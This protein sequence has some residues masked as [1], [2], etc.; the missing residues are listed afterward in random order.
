[1]RTEE[2]KDCCKF[3]EIEYQKLLSSCLTR[4]LSLY[5]SLP[6]ILQMYPNLQL[7]FMC[8]DKPPV[9]LKR[10]Q[11]SSVNELYLKHLQSFVVIFNEQVQ[12]IERSTASI[13]E[14]K[15]C[16]D[17][18]K[19]TI[20]ERQKQLFISTQIKSKLSKLRDEGHD[21]LLQKTKWK[22]VE[23]SVEYLHKKLFLLMK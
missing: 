8:I 7:Y 11:K 14:V 12:N 23:T 6:R 3:V 18:V 21:L 13:T 15:A 19:S 5:T 1:M 16:L 10:F 17:A 22:N 2:F 9:V 20:E 4:W